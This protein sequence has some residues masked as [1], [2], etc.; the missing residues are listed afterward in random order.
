[1]GCCGKM[2]AAAEGYKNLIT[3]KKVRATARRWM[4]CV[5]C[6]LKR[7]I[8][9]AAFCKRCKCFIQAKIRASMKTC[10]KWER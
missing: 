7:N 9:G 2:A 10:D 8:W 3:G 6:T 1:M 4:I 5:K